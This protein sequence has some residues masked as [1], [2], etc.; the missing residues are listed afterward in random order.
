MTDGLEKANS[1]ITKNKKHIMDAFV[2]FLAIPSISS[3]PEHK[4]DILKAANWLQNYMHKVG[5]SN[6]KILETPQHPVVFGEYNCGDASKPTVLIY[7]HYD[8]QPTDPIDLWD[9]PPFS[10]QIKKGCRVDVSNRITVC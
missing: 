10:P 8:V 6:T 9:S 5:I 2:E 3:D 1:Y 4:S 7:G